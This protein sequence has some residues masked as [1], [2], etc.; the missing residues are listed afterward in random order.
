MGL[1]QNREDTANIL[2]YYYHKSP[3]ITLHI[4]EE[5]LGIECSMIRSPTSRKYDHIHTL[6]LRLQGDLTNGINCAGQRVAQ[7]F[8]LLLNFIQHVRSPCRAGIL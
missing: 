1:T 4:L 7:Y 6:L 5:I 3:S 8:W 2:F